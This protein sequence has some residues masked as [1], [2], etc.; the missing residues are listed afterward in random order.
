MPVRPDRLEEEDFPV[1]FGRYTLRG[2]LGEGGMA[3]VFEAELMGPQGFRKKAALKVIRSGVGRSEQRLRKALI[4]EARLGGLLHHPNVVE[5]YDFG[6]TEGQF[7][8]AMEVVRG[9]G[10]DELLSE[11]IALP[12]SIA[13]EIAAQICQG[14]EHA[15]HLESDGQPTPLVHRDLKPSNVMVARN[16]LVKVLDFG[17]AKATH[18]AG[19]TTETG[20]T[21]GTP[22]YMSPEQ[23]AGDPVDARSDIFATGCI[24]Y[25]LVTGK[26][27]F[28]GD[29]VYAIMLQVIKVDDLLA[30]PE[31][32]AP[33]EA[34]V[35]GISHVLRGCLAR[36]AD[37]RWGE[38]RQL[39]RKI[40]KLQGKLPLPG[41]IRDW[42]EE[43]EVAYKARTGELVALSLDRTPDLGGMRNPHRIEGLAATEPMTPSMD[44]V[45]ASTVPLAPPAAAAPS[46]P[47]PSR[48]PAP[49]APSPPPATPGATRPMTPPVSDER[50]PEPAVW[51]LALVALLLA[52]VAGVSLLGDGTPS[53][54]P[55]VAVDPVPSGPSD[56]PGDPSAGLL[57][58]DPTPEP[59]SAPE[60]TPAPVPEPTP[61]PVAEPTPKPTPAPAPEPTPAPAPAG[62]IVHSPPSQA[63]V[64]APNR[65]EARVEGADCTP[66]VL[67]GPWS[68]SDGELQA[69]VM[70]SL[71]DGHFETELFIPYELAWRKGFRYVIRCGGRGEPEA[72]WPKSG[73]Q[74]VDALAR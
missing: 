1:P 62:R 38:A 40:R 15:H 14:L 23:A 44:A 65:L 10:L 20:M 56:E 5:T 41:P 70:S 37:Q 9:M 69:A 73:A 2:L 11:G 47:P 66:A 13:M 31:T 61:T 16:G 3:R 29:T 32:L 53:D 33:A 6:E 22:A 19:H 18:I 27:F 4:K 35:P 28:R 50:K 17:I 52:G 64:G 42:V 51:V 55:A 54:D 58:S 7:W 34:I 72:R 8:I 26:R 46:R 67:Y 57:P 63:V 48:Q 36:D 24:L 49:S 71:G 43:R 30:D 12:P 60:P 45:P 68:A 74:R 59:T 25:E 21:K 39:E